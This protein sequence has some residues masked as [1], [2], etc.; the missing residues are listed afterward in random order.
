MKNFIQ[1]SFYNNG[2]PQVP[3]LRN[4]IYLELFVLS[5]ITASSSENAVAFQPLN[6]S[7]PS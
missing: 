2:K 3:K 5:A 7:F 6:V 1:T 4:V